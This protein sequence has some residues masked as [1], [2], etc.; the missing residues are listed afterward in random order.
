[1]SID[2]NII[3]WSSSFKLIHLKEKV[4]EHEL[5]GDMEEEIVCNRW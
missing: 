5:E 2:V 4:I 3:S 1:M